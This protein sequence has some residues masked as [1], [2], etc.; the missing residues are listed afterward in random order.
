MG[1][2][3]L[4][5]NIIF[6]V[7]VT[8]SMIIMIWFGSSRNVPTGG[9][10]VSFLPARV[11]EVVEDRT[12]LNEAGARVG[13]QYLRLRLLSGERRGDIIE[14]RNML[15]PIEHAVYA[16]AGQ[17]LIV[18]FEQLPGAAD[19]D[20]FA[21]VQSYDRTPAIY[22]IITLF[23]ALLAA[24]FGKTGIKAA[25]G[26]VFTF[27]VIIFL[28]LPLIVS[29][30]P[31]AVL[32]VLLSLCI[33]MVSLIAIMGF[34]KKTYVSIAGAGI[35]IACYCVFYWVMSAALRIT[36]FNVQEADMLIVAGFNIGVS[37]LLF[38]SILIASLGALV[39]VAVSLASVTAELSVTNK[40]AGFRELF[41]SGMKIGRDIIGSS[42]NTLIL[43]FTGSFF[44]MLILFNINNFQYIVLINRVDIG[45]EILRAISASA[46]MVLCAPATV[47]IGAHVFAAKKNVRHRRQ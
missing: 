30:W 23:F 39:D 16:Q 34:E 37:E 38:C 28:L 1:N 41:A 15:F 31:P 29:G 9:E 4:D 18:F 26:L 3:K 42:S 36:G 35:G 33:I 32:T 5:K 27:V 44:I 21:H 10:G 24:V 20:Y 43:A 22:V 46:A 14:A 8:V 17:R 7:V 45:I 11:I 2:L 19:D 25:F 12:S 40:N 13:T 6:Y 47:L